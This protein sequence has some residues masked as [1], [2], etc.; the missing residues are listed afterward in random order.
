MVPHIT[1]A[2]ALRT[3]DALSTIAIGISA[4][5]DFRYVRVIGPGLAVLQAATRSREPWAYS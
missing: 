5:R 2:N 4:R 1:E 3:A